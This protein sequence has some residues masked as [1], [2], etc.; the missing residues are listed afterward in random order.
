MLLSIA[1]MNTWI[2]NR[3]ADFNDVRSTVSD[4]Q[5]PIVKVSTL[6]FSLLSFCDLSRRS[7]FVGLFLQ[8]PRCLVSREEIV[9]V[10]FVTFS[11]SQP[12]IFSRR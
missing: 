8:R 12:I 2:V 9:K 6:F 5:V 3:S 10:R 1:F 4:S 7:C 11:S